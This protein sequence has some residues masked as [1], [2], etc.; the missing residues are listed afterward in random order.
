LDEATKE[1]VESIEVISVEDDPPETY[2]AEL[3][4]GC[5]SLWNSSAIQYVYNHRNELGLSNVSV[6]LDS[7]P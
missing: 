1:I 3:A 7:M 2:N 6:N 5:N 4:D